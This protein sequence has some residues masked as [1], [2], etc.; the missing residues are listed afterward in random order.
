VARSATPMVQLKDIASVSGTSV[1][2]RGIEPARDHAVKLMPFSR[3]PVTEFG[4]RGRCW[5]CLGFVAAVDILEQLPAKV[6]QRMT[7]AVVDILAQRPSTFSLEALHKVDL[8]ANPCSCCAVHPAQRSGGRTREGR[9]HVGS[10][11]G[12]H[13]LP[14]ANTS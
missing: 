12:T 4:P 6:V 7:A 10:K 3:L 13:Y 5:R 2:E 9:F 1:L 11:T 14:L 8:P